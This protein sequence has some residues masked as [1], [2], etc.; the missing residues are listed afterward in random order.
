[1]NTK[2]TDDFNIQQAN[3][4]G[5]DPVAIEL[6]AEELPAQHDLLG[7]SS[8]STISTASTLA[9]STVGTGGTFSTIS[10]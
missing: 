2:P 9:G 3:H 1:M 5:S 10:G 7:I 4:T 6:F 8:G